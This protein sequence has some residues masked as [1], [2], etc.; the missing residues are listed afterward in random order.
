MYPIGAK[1]G[2]REFLYTHV[3]R[4]VGNGRVFHNHWKNGAEIVT[5]DQF[6][7]SKKVKIL[8]QGVQSPQEFRKRVQYL[9][10]LN[11]PYCFLSNNCEHAASYVSNGIASSPQLILYSI[12][13]LAGVCVLS[14]GARA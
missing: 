12:I 1:L 13:A 6:A 5:V 2:V 8:E 7:N 9:L 10:A 3:G 11:K 14:R 4:Y